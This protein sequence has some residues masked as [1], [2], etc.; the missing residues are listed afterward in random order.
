MACAVRVGLVW[1]FG[2]LRERWLGAFGLGDAWGV[3]VRGLG[4][5]GLGLAGFGPLV[6]GLGFGWIW[7]RALGFV[8]HGMLGDGI[9][10]WSGLRAWLSG[11]FVLDNGC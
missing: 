9:L 2:L 1:G 8:R 6:R 4:C 10:Q 7:A 5:C 11:R 3:V